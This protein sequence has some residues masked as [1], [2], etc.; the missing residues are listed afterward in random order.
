MVNERLLRQ[1]DIVTTKDLNFNIHV[2]GAG[3]IGSFT[4]LLLAKMGCKNIIVYDDDTV[5]DH[6]IA[7]QFFKE[8]QLEM[9]KV[10]ALK[11]NVLEQTGIE[12]EHAEQIDEEY[13]NSGLVI[14]AVDSME[15]R[16][17]LGE[18]YKDKD[19]Y[20]IDARMG[21]LQLEIYSRTSK[22]YPSTLVEPTDVSHDP[23]TAKAISFNCAVIGGLIANQVRLF[24]TKKLKEEDLMYL[25]ETNSFLKS[26]ADQVEDVV[27][28]EDTI[29]KGVV[30]E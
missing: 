26:G 15:E 21:G 17:R 19:I 27:S 6:N 28:T 3:G 12:I 16:I 13:I 14:F 2:I 1:L 29:E 24:A 25:F 18:I 10:E 8:D 4:V 11:V 23:C 20:I 9:N 22:N 5:E 7:S 30:E